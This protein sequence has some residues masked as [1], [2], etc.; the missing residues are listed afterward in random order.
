MTR[1]IRFEFLAKFGYAARGV[2]FLMVAGLALFSGIAG[3][4]PETK[5]A[6]SALLEQPFGRIWVGLIGFGLL[7]FVA[8]RLAQS[9]TDADGHGDDGKAIAIRASLFGSAVTYLG[10]AS[11][12]LGHAFTVSADGGGS[13]EKGMA[14]WVMSQPF[15]SYIAIAIGV[16]FIVGGIVTAIK[17]ATRSFEK[18][19]H[20]PN[21]TRML[22]Y[23]CMYGLISRGIVFA[24]TGILF[25]YAGFSVD[26]DQ[27]GG[28]AE[29][30]EWL[31]Q[32]PFGAF[33]YLVMALGL[34]AFGIYNLIAARYRT[35]RGPTMADVKQAAT[36]KL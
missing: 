18:Y 30:L 6:L 22:T 25:T 7:G 3:G 20:V 2:V 1:N 15:G 34:A 4:R 19:I 8:W 17:G 29:A 16:G 33:L 28:I 13:G 21:R 31:R 11:F 36:L 27:A 12:A 23:I 10:L 9:I 14:G 24:I 32:L 35:V 26:P 5:S